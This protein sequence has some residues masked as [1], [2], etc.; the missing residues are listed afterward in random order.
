M[1]PSPPI[2]VDVGIASKSNPWPPQTFLQAR[3]GDRIITW[4]TFSYSGPN[5]L[6]RLKT[7]VLD[8]NGKEIGNQLTGPG[9]QIFNPFEN[10]IRGVGV[11][12]NLSD[13]TI[14]GIYDVEFSIWREDDTQQY[15]S[16]LK[17][18]WLRLAFEEETETISTPGIPTGTST[19]EVN[20]SLTYSTGGT[21]SNLGHSL[22]Y[23]FDWGDGSYSSWS[24]SITASHSWSRHGTHTVRT[25]ARCATHTS[26]VSGWSSGRS[27]NITPAASVSAIINGYSPSSTV[28]VTVGSSTPIS[29]TFT[30]T[31]NTEWSFNA[32]ATVWD[33]NGNQV[34]NYSKTL[35]TPLQS[36]QQTTVSWTHPVNQAGDYWLQFGVWK[37]TPYVSE[38]LL[39]KKP[40]LSQKSIVVH[41]PLKFSAGDS[42]R[43]TAN[44]NV[45]TASGTSYPEIT[46]PD[47]PGYAPSGSTGVVLSGPESVDGYVWWEIQY[48]AGYTGWSVEDWLQKV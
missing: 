33:S 48:D 22:E 28:Q 39:D 6:V 20:Q 27:V 47:Y 8:S 41:E 13:E 35:S 2:L 24:S 36:G 29:V 32:G 26:I 37:A 15:D 12:Y 9:F 11:E 34:A 5:L 30:N 42:V 40:S 31:G 1:P 18:G 23:R 43:T 7:T 45:R 38:N 46:D 19:G 25:Q 10:P 17:S 14:P 4:Y 44:L 21:S 3:P 16:V